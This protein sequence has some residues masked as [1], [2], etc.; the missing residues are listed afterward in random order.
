MGY[1]MLPC[2]FI[3]PHGKEGKRYEKKARGSGCVFHSGCRVVRCTHTGAGPNYYHR[4]WPAALRATRSR[5]R[6]TW[7]WM[8][9]D[10]WPLDLGWA[11]GLGA[12]ALGSGPA[13]ASGLDPR[14]LGSARWRL[15]LGRRAL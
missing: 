15:G 6:D 9:M 5:P 12:R 10:P 14:A 1:G 8:G 13:R 7:P 3:T 2:R 4:A 11:M